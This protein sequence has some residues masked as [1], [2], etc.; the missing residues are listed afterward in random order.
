MVLKH[1]R[2]LLVAYIVQLTLG[3]SE[4]LS[5]HPTSY[6]FNLHVMKDVF[7]TTGLPQDNKTIL[8]LHNYSAHPEEIQWYL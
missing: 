2:V 4:S 1:P 8:S 5:S 3:K 7:R 6:H